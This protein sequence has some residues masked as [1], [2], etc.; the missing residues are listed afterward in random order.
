MTLIS[1]NSLSTKWAWRLNESNT[2]TTSQNEETKRIKAKNLYKVTQSFPS[3][4]SY[5]TLGCIFCTTIFLSYIRSIDAYSHVLRKCCV[6]LEPKRLMCIVC[7]C[8][9]VILIGKLGL[10]CYDDVHL[11][12]IFVT[13]CVLVY[14]VL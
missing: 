7:E 11:D 3:S 5:A 6:H 14:S 12:T 13:R 2:N 10:K 4:F 1:L 9:F 8:R